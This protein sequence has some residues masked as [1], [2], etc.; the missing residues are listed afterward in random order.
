[1]LR[2]SRSPRALVL[3]TGAVIVAVVTAVVVASDL[4]ALHRRAQDLGPERTV[5]VARRDLPLGS[6]V[7]PG[8]LRER[9]IHASQLPVGVFRSTGDV[10]G[11]VVQ[12]PVLRGDFVSARQLAPRHRQGLDGAIPP[13]MRA[14]RVVVADAVRPRAGA[15]VDVIASFE[16]AGATPA[17]DGSEALPATVVARGVFVITSDDARTSEGLRALGVTLL[18]TPREA[19]DLAFAS[20]HGVLT[21]A[22][23][24][25]EDARDT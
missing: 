10:A 25:P 6:T 17:E 9:E 2:L 1:M 24:P 21:I 22:L 7:A 5:V 4:A 11:R 23:V 16:D 19:R 15:S 14:M 18:V 3:W 13:G 20:T 12:V 8:D